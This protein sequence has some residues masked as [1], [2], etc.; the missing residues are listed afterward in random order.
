M[1]GAWLGVAVLAGAWMLGSNYFQPAT[2][3]SWVMLVVI[4]AT[5]LEPAGRCLPGRRTMALALLALVPAVWYLP[6][7]YRAVPILM[8]LGLAAQLLPFPRRWPGFWGRGAL[9]AGAVLSS[10]AVALW[11]YA[12][13]TARRH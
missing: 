8:G 3:A 6:T 11:L 2:A 1:K 12:A 5:L 13:L 7:P 4:G 10:Q 9:A